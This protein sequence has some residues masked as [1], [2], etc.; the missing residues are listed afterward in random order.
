MAGKKKILPTLLGF[1]LFSKKRANNKVSG[2]PIGLSAG[3]LG[4]NPSAILR[5]PFNRRPNNKDFLPFLN[6]STLGWYFLIFS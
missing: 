3:T 2:S 6:S 5:L 1:F 4:Y